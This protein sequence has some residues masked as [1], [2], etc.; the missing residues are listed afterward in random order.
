MV[1]LTGIVCRLMR[2]A[3]RGAGGQAPSAESENPGENPDAG[4]F[5]KLTRIRGIGIVTENRLYAAG[6][7]SY[8][9]LG[10]ATPEKLQKILGTPRAG[11][12]FEAWI[13]EARGLTGKA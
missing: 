1:Q 9:A 6:I 8:A 11:A 4:S 7:K 12:K 2:C 13:A 10:R 3:V 5:D